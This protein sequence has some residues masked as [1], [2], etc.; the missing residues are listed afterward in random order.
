VLRSSGPPTNKTL[1][2]R[3]RRAL[4]VHGRSA[5]G[6]QQGKQADVKRIISCQNK[7][8]SVAMQFSMP[9]G[10]L[11]VQRRAVAFAFVRLHEGSVRQETYFCS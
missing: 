10:T 9:A 11:T 1:R 3:T 6:Y 5:A 2:V 8:A 4:A 7:I